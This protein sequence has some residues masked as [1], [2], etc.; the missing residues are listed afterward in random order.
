MESFL[1]EVGDGFRI[2]IPKTVRN[3]LNIRRGDIV[4][5]TV[6]KVGK[7][8]NLKQKFYGGV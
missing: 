4:R 1:A 3:L 7:S 2:V 6:E 5:V 8:Q